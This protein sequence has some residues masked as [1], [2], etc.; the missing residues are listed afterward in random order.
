MRDFMHRL[1]SAADLP[2]EPIPGLPL[3]E[4]AGDRRVLIEHHNGVTEYGTQ[5]ISVKVKFGHVCITG[6]SLELTQ[7]TREQL[8][9]SGQINSVI[10]KRRER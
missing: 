4:I 2:E 9:V 10:L 8:I 7:M 1:S 3:V 5:Q 6:C